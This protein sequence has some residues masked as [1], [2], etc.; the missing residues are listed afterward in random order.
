MASWL[1]LLSDNILCLCD[2]NFHDLFISGTRA[3]ILI[4]VEGGVEIP[5]KFKVIAKSPETN[6]NSLSVSVLGLN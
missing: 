1:G 4:A 6:L 3:V 5:Q 2:F